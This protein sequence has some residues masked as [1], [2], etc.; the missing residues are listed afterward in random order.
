M[1]I[2]ECLGQPRT[3]PEKGIA[4]RDF[5]LLESRGISPLEVKQVKMLMVVMLAVFA[6]VALAE[7]S[8][9]TVEG[10]LET[11][12]LQYER[13]ED[14]F[15]VMMEDQEG[16]LWPVMYIGVDP[17]IEACYLAAFTPAVVPESGQARQDALETIMELNWNSLFSKFEVNPETGEVSLSYV[18]STENGVGYEAF[19]AI[20]GVLFG[21]L[22][23]TMEVLSAIQ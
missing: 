8:A 1:T 22:E 9:D 10:Y 17:E 16:E 13:E 18:F 19:E 12:G 21:T 11:M 14:E 6:T 15:L 3:S 4:D 20:M 7:I 5:P 2:P 23:E